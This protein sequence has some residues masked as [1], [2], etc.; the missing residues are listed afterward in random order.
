ME[1]F[2][3]WLYCQT[4]M[5]KTLRWSKYVKYQNGK[6]ARYNG[7]RRQ[8]VAQHTLSKLTVFSMIMPSL[9]KI[10]GDMVDFDL[11]NSC[12]VYHDFGEPLRNQKYDILANDKKNSD[13][14][15]EYELF[16]KFLK[17]SGMSVHTSTYNEI[18]KA[19]LLQFALTSYHEFD[20]GA[21]YTMSKILKNEVERNTAIL[22]QIVEKW[23]YFF[24]AYEHKNKH[25]TIWNDV[26]ERNRELINKWI[27]RYPKKY[28]K[29][30]KE[31]F[32]D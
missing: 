10:F 9:K 22:F 16:I 11:L 23:E 14:V 12:I 7:I 18:I 1:F 3:P 25:P 24:Y 30:L 19:F 2:G 32:T 28:H 6:P 27:I 8:N 26:N 29:P 31:F 4:G 20:D 21:K 15:A 17:K 13:D 5:D